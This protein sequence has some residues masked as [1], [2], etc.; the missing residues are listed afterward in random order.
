MNAAGSRL[1]LREKEAVAS[2]ERVPDN[3]VVLPAEVI[4]VAGGIPVG[5][6]HSEGPCGGGRARALKLH[7]S[8]GA[9]WL[10]GGVSWPSPSLTPS[11]TPS[12]PSAVSF[13]AVEDSENK[14]PCSSPGRTKV[15]SSS[16]TETTSEEE[17]VDEEEQGNDENK[18]DDS[19][20][21]VARSCLCDPLPSDLLS[22]PLRNPSSRIENR[23]GDM[24]G[25]LDRR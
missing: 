24:I 10:I 19:R 2:V 16:F 21:F 22:R 8:R 5:S 7:S 11:S 20:C 14:L 1:R 18:G 9:A 3:K 25:I 12:K 17:L 15:G 23:E 6:L 4:V 13:H